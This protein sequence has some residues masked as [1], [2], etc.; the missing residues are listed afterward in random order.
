[1]IKESKRFTL[2]FLMFIISINAHTQEDSFT[3]A[4]AT[5]DFTDV[6]RTW[7]GFG[8]NYV[9][10]AQTYDHQNNAQDYG[11]F[12]FLDEKKKREIIDLVFGDD[13]LKPA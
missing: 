4:K 1:M 10:T 7:D 5:V 11:G 12:K 13:G 6:L 8:F 2:I 3:A 9:E